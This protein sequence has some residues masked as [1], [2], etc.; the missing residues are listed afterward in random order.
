LEE[1]HSTGSD[2]LEKDEGG[3]LNA[4]YLSSW[5]N[6]TKRAVWRTMRSVHGLDPFS[7]Q[8][9]PEELRRGTFGPDFEV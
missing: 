4:V 6:V 7:R 5:D 9:L 2:L 1:A 3:E 8:S